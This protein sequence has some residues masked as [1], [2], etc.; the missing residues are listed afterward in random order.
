MEWRCIIS[1]DLQYV[2]RHRIL[3]STT[4]H[5][6]FVLPCP[7]RIASRCSMPRASRKMSASIQQSNRIEAQ[8][9]PK[10][11]LRIIHTFFCLKMGLHNIS[12]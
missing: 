1:R 6:A 9:S 3:F 2:G 8:E 7:V 4:L 5:L 11:D 12:E 10:L